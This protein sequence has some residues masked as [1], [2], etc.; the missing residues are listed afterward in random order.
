[1]KL[2][3]TACYAIQAVVF[4]ALQ[5]ENQIVIGHRAAKELGIPEGFL[6]RILVALSRARILWSIKGPNGG[7]RLARPAKDI[8]LLDVVEAVEGPLRGSVLFSPGE[9]SRGVDRRLEA[10][11]Q[12]IT[13]SIRKQLQKVRISDLATKGSLA[14]SR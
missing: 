13:D 1:M 6:L 8:S 10:I 5:G 7:Y 9:E 14:K 2:S 11:C 3:R 12:Q 4:M